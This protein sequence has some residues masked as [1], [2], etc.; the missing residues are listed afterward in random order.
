MGMPG[1]YDM[2]IARG[3]TFTIGFRKKAG[4]PA[5]PINLTGWKVRGQIRTKPGQYGL[6]TT[7]TLVLDMTNGNEVE[8]SDPANGLTTVL[9]TSEQT[10]DLC[11]ENKQLD[12]YYEIELYND[13][14]S[15]ETVD[16]LM[17]GKITVMPE[18]AR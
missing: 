4:T 8:I 10:I 5:E 18:T 3:K 2:V 17:I 9:L 13:N 15:P 16:G 1:K 6:T 7:E 11:P 14:D 12:L